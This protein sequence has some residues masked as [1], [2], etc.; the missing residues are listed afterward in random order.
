MTRRRLSH[1]VTMAV[2]ATGGAGRRGIPVRRR[3]KAALSLAATVTMAAALA[4]LAAG[5]AWAK[6][7]PP[8]SIH[9]LCAAAPT[10]GAL[11]GSVC[12]L[13][14]G[15]TT[16]PNAYSATIAVSK[17]GS[18][19]PNV[20]FAVTAGS[21]PPGL[22]LAAPSGTSTVITGNPTQTGTFNFTIK[23][24]DGGLT[25]TMAYQITITV[26]GPPDQLVC[27]PAANGGFLESGVCVLPDAVIGQSYQ[28]HLVTSH[29][30]GGAL[31]VVSGALPSGLSL[32]ATFT[33]SGDVVSGTPGQLTGGASFTVQGT[34]DQGQ[35]LYQAYSVAVDPNTPLAINAS[36]GTDL[37]G[38]VGGAFAQDFFVSGGAAP[39][40]W[41]VASGQL[42]P[43]LTLQT[44]AGPRDANNELAGTPTTAG[45]FGF[46]MRL[47]DYNGQQATQKF[48]V[49]IDPPLQ[50]T[51]TTLPAG[52]VGVPYSH[53][54]DLSAQGGTPPYNWFVVNNISELPP[55]LTLDTTA[56]DFNNVL[57]GTPTQAGTF[58]FPMQVQDSQD[59]TV[60]ATLTVTINP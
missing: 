59:N 47:T 18:A 19:G 58:S 52:T 4:G 16:A 26:Q 45:T 1:L 34:G 21:L 50:V 46:T 8:P 9:L 29:M 38:M 33:G 15:Q 32:P 31:S 22:S 44:T 42:P 3:T 54:L 49:T 57:A 25:S 13:A 7:Y 20:T 43:G 55:G 23:A 24:T 56:P 48:T 28:G 6:P 35:P 12:A 5:P 39:Y 51:P 60:N 40:T 41:S 14:S 37:V 27:T 10:N 11:H 17:A 53:D 2:S 30:A 36:G